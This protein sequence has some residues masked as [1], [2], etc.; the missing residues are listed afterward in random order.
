M[1]QIWSDLVRPGASNAR[2]PLEERVRDA[3][4]DLWKKRKQAQQSPPETEQ[5]NEGIACRA[6]TQNLWKPIFAVDAVEIYDQG[7]F[8]RELNSRGVK[9]PSPL[10]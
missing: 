2:L 10:A 9:S 7:G 1:P 3:E 4:I 5:D 6:W 8:P